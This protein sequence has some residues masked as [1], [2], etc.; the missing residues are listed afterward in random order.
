MTEASRKDRILGVAERLFSH[1][2]PAKTTVADIAR[3]CG[4]GV[5][6]VYLD[7][8]SKEAILAALSRKNVRALASRM[9]AAAPEGPA[10]R[11]IVA[12]LEARVVALFE[13]AE[14]GQHGCDLVR[15]RASR[16][17]A[18][19]A[20]EERAA[21]VS[22][23]QPNLGLEVRTLLEDEIRRGVELGE[24]GAVDIHRTV[25][26]LELAFAALSPPAVFQLKRDDAVEKA[27]SLAVLVVF[28]LRSGAAADER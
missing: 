6:S 19:P 4:I 12:M 10:P 8:S 27:R 14:G 15:C 7:F 3:A 16:G 18:S 26:L 20:T 28:G 23:F 21:P 11:R 25:D 13:L 17:S 22:P 9:H 5:G 2:G 1:Y 24:L